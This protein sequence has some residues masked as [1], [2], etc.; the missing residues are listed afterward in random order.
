MTATQQHTDPQ[1]AEAL[2]ARVRTTWTAGDFGRIAV[3]Y[4]EGAAAFIARLG[5]KRGVRDG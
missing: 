3:G 1:P 5:L 2:R 4:E